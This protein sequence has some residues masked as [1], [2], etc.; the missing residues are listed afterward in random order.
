VGKSS[1]FR[2]LDGSIPLTSGTMLLNDEIFDPIRFF[3]SGQASLVPQQADVIG[4]LSVEDAIRYAYALRRPGERISETYLDAK[5]AVV[6]LPHHRSRLIRNLSGGERKRVS[7]LLELL[8]SPKLVLFDE[9]NS[10]LDSA[11][12]R[13]LMEHLSNEVADLTDNPDTVIICISHALDHCLKQD[14]EVIALSRDMKAN[15]DR[16][17][18]AF[19]G[20]G[21]LLLSVT[22]STTPADCL[23]KLHDG[24]LPEWER[25]P[26]VIPENLAPQEHRKGPGGKQT[27]IRL[28]TLI[29]REFRRRHRINMK[30]PHTPLTATSLD[31]R[32]RR[33]RFLKGIAVEILFPLAFGIIVAIM[34]YQL[35]SE[36]LDLEHPNRSLA[37]SV[38]LCTVPG[39]LCVSFVVPSIFGDW[40][41]L[42]REHRWGI[43]PGLQILARFLNN[44]PRAVILGASCGYFFSANVEPI[45][46]WAPIGWVGACVASSILMMCG[47]LAIGLCVGV[48][49]RDLY[50]AMILLLFVLS[51]L[52]IFSG[53]AISLNQLGGWAFWV[54][55]LS[56]TR[57]GTSAMMSANGL[58]GFPLDPTDRFWESTNTALFLDLGI[59]VALI[60]GYLLLATLLLRH[61]F[62]V[63]AAKR[64]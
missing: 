40:G 6:N 19:E 26:T 27:L 18:V 56:P 53:G 47:C 37:S 50:S 57:W 34:A 62:S 41:Y 30:P 33:G 15:E 29:S 44:L 16:T 32:L 2:V 63:R 12:D 45:D 11:E 51:I 39:F 7:M 25:L 3:H 28:A 36:G 9:P 24:V 8:T 42:E 35:A 17:Y 21:D 14:T 48:L 58:P 54:A 61:Q 22:E 5:L 59:L 4:D 13:R 38:I 10:G 52:I 46:N 43:S 55:A 23:E 20:G 1:L 60:V 64:R 31:R 49:L